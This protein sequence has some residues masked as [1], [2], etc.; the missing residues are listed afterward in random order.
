[1]IPLRPAYVPTE[2]QQDIRSL[3]QECYALLHGRQL[4]FGS[5]F[6]VRPEGGKKGRSSPI[7]KEALSLGGIRSQ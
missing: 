6:E 7:A 5:L 4:P 2:V 1:M 3:A